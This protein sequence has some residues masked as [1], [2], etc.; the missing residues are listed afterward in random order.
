MKINGYTKIEGVGGKHKY[1]EIT[2]YRKNKLSIKER[3]IIFTQKTRIKVFG[4]MHL[5]LSKL[6]DKLVYK[7][8]TQIGTIYTTKK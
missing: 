6:D 2:Y 5:S 7:N 8:W 1:G 4:W 3:L